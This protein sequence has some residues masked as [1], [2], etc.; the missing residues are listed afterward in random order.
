MMNV[1]T[2]RKDIFE[3]NMCYLSS[4]VQKLNFDRRSFH[5]DLTCD[6]KQYLVN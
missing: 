4:S 1:T 2:D 3:I 6:R 5:L